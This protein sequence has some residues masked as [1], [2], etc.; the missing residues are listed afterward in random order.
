MNGDKGHLDDEGFLSIVDR[1]SRFAKIGGEMV[2][3]GALEQSI[4]KALDDPEAEVMAVAIPDAKK[5]E[6]VCLVHTLDKE[7]TDFIALLKDA[8][9]ENIMI[10]S[11]FIKIEELPKL[12][13]GKR[14][15]TTA[16][17]MV[18]DL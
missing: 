6:V 3:L 5:G 1:Y 13:T 15:Y 12:G 4:V 11:K 2:S 9:M 8:G 10:P 17:K 18:L 7:P 16:K 14:D